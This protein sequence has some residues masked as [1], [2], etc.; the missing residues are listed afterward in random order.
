[1]SFKHIYLTLSGTINMGDCGPGSNGDEGVYIYLSICTHIYQISLTTHLHRL[2]LLAGPI[3]Y[4][5]CKH[6]AGIEKILLVRVKRSRGEH[7]LWVPSYFP[8][9][10]HMSFSLDLDCFSDGRQVVVLLL[11]CGMLL[12]GLVKNKLYHS[13][14][15]ANHTFLYS[16]CKH[17]SSASIY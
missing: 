13:F 10:S 14:A 5:L 2:S 3:G 11:F 17:S 6:W 12:S 4:I 9:V 7:R 15:I 8:A 16:L 1:M